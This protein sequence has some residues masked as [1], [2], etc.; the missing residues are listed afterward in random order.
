MKKIPARYELSEEDIKEAIKY[1][2]NKRYEN[3]G[4]EHEF[5]VALSVEASGYSQH[6]NEKQSSNITALVIKD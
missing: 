3:D 2:L 1:W 4:Y 6:F 5:T